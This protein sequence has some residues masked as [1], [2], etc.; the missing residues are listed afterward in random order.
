MATVMADNNRVAWTYTTNKAVDYRVSAKE[1]YVGDVTD[2][3][4]YG[5]SAAA[6]TVPHLPK[7]WRMRAVKC[8]SAGNRDL[9]IP[10]Y[11]AAATIGTAGTTVVR[12]LNGV[13]TTYT[14][15]GIIR[16]EQRPKWMGGITEAA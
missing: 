3:A 14:S 11:T 7:G 13:D 12:N 10:F 6:S 9:W 5:G 4:K 8:T 2:G 15:T 16:E 1:V